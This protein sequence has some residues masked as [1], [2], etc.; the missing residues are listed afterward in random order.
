M[1]PAPHIGRCPHR[2]RMDG[3]PK[4]PGRGWTKLRGTQPIPACCSTGPG[5]CA[6]RTS[7]DDAHAMLLRIAAGALVRGPCRALVG[8]SECPGARRPGRRRSRAARWRWSTMPA[9]R[10]RPVCRA[11]IPGR[12]YRPAL[13]EGPRRGAGLISSGWTP[14]SR[15]PSASRARN[16]GRAAAYEALG[17]TA[18]ALAHYRLA[19]AYPETFYGQIALA[20]IEAAPLLHLNDTRGGGGGD[21][22]NRGR[23]PDARRSRCWPIWARQATC[24]CSWTAMPRP[25]PRP[26]ISSG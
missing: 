9:S 25:I 11:A 2:A 16:I 19:A 5:R 1:P 8:G 23:S 14:A 26:G 10:R 4:A 24:A 7:D 12:L 15:A 18:S 6:W 20:H 13:S 3:W 21:K 22:R 17:D